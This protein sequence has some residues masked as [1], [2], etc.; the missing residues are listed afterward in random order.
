MKYFVCPS[1]EKKNVILFKRLRIL[2]A[3]YKGSK[4]EQS[5]KT[6]KMS[7]YYEFLREPFVYS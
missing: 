1:C 3:H 5:K 6:P 4:I 2:N 7:V